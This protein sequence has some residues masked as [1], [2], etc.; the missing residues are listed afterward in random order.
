MTLCGL[1][2]MDGADA[3]RPALTAMLASSSLGLPALRGVHLDGPFGVVTAADVAG[4]PVPPIA[5]DDDGLTV[6]VLATRPPVPGPLRLASRSSRAEPG[7]GAL[8]QVARQVAD[9]YRTTG[10]RPPRGLPPDRLVL[11][12]DPAGRRLMVVRTGSRAVELLLGSDSRH[13]AFGTE[14][15][16]LAAAFEAPRPRGRGGEPDSPVPR[17]RA[18]AVGD[19]CRAEGG[20]AP[21]GLARTWLTKPSP[22]SG[23]SP[24]SEPSAVSRLG[25][26]AAGRTAWSVS[27]LGP[28]EALTIL[29][30][31]ARPTARP[32]RVPRLR[33]VPPLGLGDPDAAPA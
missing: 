33:L 5:V 24:I 31:A 30:P 10:Q 19:A 20:L 8:R 11:I 13:V 18:R 23:L 15:A 7:A 29:V 27:R 2:R 16:Q 17:P 28:G 32:A 6:V 26:A 21:D 22:I 14:R 12:W 9:A 3:R 1:L 4:D 25:R